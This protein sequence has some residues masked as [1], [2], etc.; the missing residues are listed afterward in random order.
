MEVPCLARHAFM[1]SAVI[2][3]PTSSS[4]PLNA[5]ISASTPRLLSGSFVHTPSLQL[6]LSCQ[7]LEEFFAIV[8]RMSPG[9]YSIPTWQ[10]HRVVSTPGQPL[11][12][13]SSHTNLLD[14][15]AHRAMAKSS[16]FPETRRK[17]R[18]LS[19]VFGPQTVDF[20]IAYEFCSF[21]YPLG[22]NFI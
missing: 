19:P 1:S 4:R 13:S 10:V 14:P 7:Y 8:K 18:I 11:N 6:G 16:S 22:S 12:S 17:S 21:H 3:S 20:S 9:A 5:T 2:A 15:R